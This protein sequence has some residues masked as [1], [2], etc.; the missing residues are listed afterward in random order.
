M[1]GGTFDKAYM[2]DMVKDHEKD[3]A[4]FQKEAN[5]GSDPD[6][7]NWASAT[8]PKKRSTR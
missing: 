3:I 2:Q 7:K 5:S 4:E 6:L 8:L 1:S